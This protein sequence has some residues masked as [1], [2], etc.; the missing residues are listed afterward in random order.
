MS[1]AVYLTIVSVTIA[2]FGLIYAIW[3]NRVILIISQSGADI[4][5]W[6]RTTDD[7]A[8]TYMMDVKIINDSLRPVRIRGY[9]L[10]LLWKD[11]DFHWL[12]DPGEGSAKDMKYKIPR[13]FLEFS[14][15]EIINH[16]K[17]AEGLMQPGDIVEG[18]L[19]GR[20]LT[21]I[22]ALFPHGSEIVMSL[23]V[24]DQRGKAHKA[25]FTFFVWRNLAED[26]ITRNRS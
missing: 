6:V 25:P 9:D 19:L 5:N 15:N 23:L 22:P 14:R 4:N 17:M 8:T 3:R 11:L 2:L 21:P 20:G 24:Y 12:Y 18:L 10:E 16:R 13:T 7:G 1:P 26:Y